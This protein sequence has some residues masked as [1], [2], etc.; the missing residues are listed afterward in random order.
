MSKIKVLYIS[1]T[2][3]SSGPT[4]VIF[5]IVKYLDRERFEPVILTL[6][7]EPKDSALPRFQELGLNFYSLNLSRLQGFL[8][9]KSALKDF[10][11][12]HQPDV[13]HSHGIRPD[14]FSAECLQEY[15][16]FT[17]IHNYPYEDYTM[18]YG[19]LLGRYLAWRQIM[20][21][22]K[23]DYPV[24]ICESQREHIQ[25][26]E[27][28]S[29]TIYNGVDINIFNPATNDERLA[30]RQKLGMPVDRKIFVS[31]GHLMNRKDPETVIRGFLASNAN[32]YTIILFIGDG[33][34]RK[35]CQK[36]S[37]GKDCIKF[38]GTVNNVHDYIRAADYF[39]SASLSEGLGYVVLEALAGGI[40][41]C[42]SDIEPFKEIISY[43]EKAGLLFPVGDSQSLAT[44]IERLF[45]NENIQEMSEAG[46]EIVNQY[47]NAKKCQKTIKIYMKKQTVN[48]TL[49]YK[50]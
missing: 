33:P 32:H 19:Q 31:V 18:K 20:A 17:T 40:P 37:Q 48:N 28:A 35:H 29:H 43:N 46:F 50:T 6:S 22:R 36:L 30:L 24:A 44:S 47:F 27:I 23:I 16:R 5:N 1:S 8:M 9:G 3:G 15:K 38:T 21:F 10:V 34:L 45:L 13:I 4:N 26:Y 49:P 7:P 39:I 14:I 2:L 25:S 41:V 11:A 12:K 42:L